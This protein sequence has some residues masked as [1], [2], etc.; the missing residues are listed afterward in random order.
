MFGRGICEKYKSW[1]YISLAVRLGKCFVS[2]LVFFANTPPKL[3]ISVILH[4]TV[5]MICWITSRIHISVSARQSYHACFCHIITKAVFWIYVHRVLTLSWK[6][7]TKTLIL[8]IK[9]RSLNF[10]PRLCLTSMDLRYLMFWKTVLQRKLCQT[11]SQGIWCIV[12][13]DLRW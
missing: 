6:Y 1:D 4:L 8:M 2:R 12:I 3:D 10:P 13:C 5:N 7:L 11:S 9:L